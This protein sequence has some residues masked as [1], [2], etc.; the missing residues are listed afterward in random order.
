[1]SDLFGSRHFHNEVMTP[2]Q[3]S[4]DIE[5]DLAKF[6]TKYTAS[7]ANDMVICITDNPMGFPSFEAM[8]TIEVTDVPVEREQLVVHLNTFHRKMDIDR[9]L[10]EMADKGVKYILAVSGDGHERLHRLEPEELGM[11]AQNVTSVELISYIRR[12]Y[13]DTF[14]IGVAYNHYEPQ[15]SEREKLARKFDAGAE[16]I[17]T[18]PVIR[19]NDNIDWLKTCSVPVIVEAWMTKR[20]DLVAQCVG[21]ELPPEDLVYDPVE[22]YFTLKDQYPEFGVYFAFLGMKKQINHL[23]IQNA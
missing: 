20:I 3:D 13:P 21:Y 17:I 14:S 22:N 5:R 9:M 23:G 19:R 12:E 2:K 16:F 1:M 10:K 15:E 4:E 11:S 18:Q 6:E 7:L 8:E